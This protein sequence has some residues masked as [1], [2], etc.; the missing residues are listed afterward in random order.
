MMMRYLLRRLFTFIPLLL[1]ILLVSFYLGLRTPG[2]AAEQRLFELRQVINTNTLS[3]LATEAIRPLFYVSFG[4]WAEPDTLYRL[5]DPVERRAAERLLYRYGNWT[6]IQRYR[7][8]VHQVDDP[9]VRLALRQAW[10]PATIHALVQHS[11]GRTL[12]PLAAAW[13][14]VTQRATP[15]K[16]YVPVLHWHGLDNAYHAWLSDLLQGNWGTSLQSRASV[17]SLI[18]RALAWTMGMALAVLLISLALAIP[19][20]VYLATHPHHPLRYLLDVALHVLYAVPNYWA[21]TLLIW[22]LS[23]QWG[24]FPA[25]GTGLEA[26]DSW[27][28]QFLSLMHHLVLPLFCWALPGVT[29]LANQ[30]KASMQEALTQDYV[31]A[32]SARGLPPTWVVWRHALRTAWLPII[33]LVGQMLPGLIGGSVAIEYIFALPG[34]GRLATT[35]FSYRDYPLIYGLTLLIGMATVLGVLGADLLYYRAD[36][37]LRQPSSLS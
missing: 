11:S 1:L 14:A 35:A 7:A 2:G 17:G 33:T 23:A 25:F 15:W 22:L 34:M 21:A 24:W 32:A 9:E 5:I 36:P 3:P 37:R 28:R 18:G 26:D 12:V 6:E 27:G 31:K 8:L 19:L 10:D 16:T 20:G 29:Y 13:Q 4:V 30:V